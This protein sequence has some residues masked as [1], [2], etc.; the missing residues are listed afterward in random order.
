MKQTLLPRGRFGWHCMLLLLAG[1]CGWF[2]WFQ[3]VA[4]LEPQP[5]YRL[6]L[7]EEARQVTWNLLGPWLNVVYYDN[8]GSTYEY[9]LLDNGEKVFSFDTHRPDSGWGRYVSDS[10]D[11]ETMVIGHEPGKMHLYHI[12]PHLQARKKLP[13][14]TTS[15]STPSVSPKGTYSAVMSKLRFVPFQQFCNTN[16]SMLFSCLLTFKLGEQMLQF[17]P[18]LRVYRTSDLKLIGDQAMPVFMSDWKDRKVLEDGEHIVYVPS[19][20]TVETTILRLFNYRTGKI[21]R[22]WPELKDP[23]LDW[24][25]SEHFLIQTTDF[26][27]RS[28][29]ILNTRTLSLLNLGVPPSTTE[30]HVK[31]HRENWAVLQTNG[32]D[33]ASPFWSKLTICKR[34]GDMLQN[35]DFES[36]ES[37]FEYRPISHQDQILVTCKRKELVPNWHLWVHRYPWLRR[38]PLGERTYCSV[39]DLASGQELLQEELRKRASSDGRFLVCSNASNTE[40]QLALYNLPL[41]PLS[42]WAI[43]LPRVAGVLPLLLWILYAFR[44]RCVGNV[45]GC[46]KANLKS[47]SS[48]QA[49]SR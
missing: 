3:L 37:Y 41:I 45:A 14:F 10:S 31:P 29:Y 35:W 24:I 4:M 32:P 6:T 38:I 46:T 13:G 12:N 7:K 20:N 16:P 25:D 49:K 15:E 18:L 23:S 44:C 47:S 39:L 43:W 8:S 21:V 26:P 42:R 27:N 30:V 22:E 48:E 2:I 5:R 1:A 9:R 17:I 36:L 11:I 40:V 34:T 19:S 33:A 28:W